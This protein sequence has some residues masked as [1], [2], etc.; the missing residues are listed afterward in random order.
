MSTLIERPWIAHTRSVAPELLAGDLVQADH[1]LFGL[2]WV[3]RERLGGTPCFYGTRVPIKTLF[4]YFEANHTLEEF[5]AD[6]DGIAR[7]GRW[8]LGIGPPGFACGVAAGVSR[9]SARMPRAAG[10]ARGGCCSTS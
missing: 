7:T 10:V 2:V 6:F 8:S 4:D 3:N 1:P 9:Q 5:L